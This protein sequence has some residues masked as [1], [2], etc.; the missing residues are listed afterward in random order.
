[1]Y[2]YTSLEKNRESKKW[3][4]CGY[5]KNTHMAY[6]KNA[7]AGVLHILRKPRSPSGGPYKRKVCSLIALYGFFLFEA[8]VGYLGQKILLALFFPAAYPLLHNSFL[9]LPVRAL[10]QGG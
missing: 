6:S 7:K 2:Y 1:M 10:R 4:T 8:H 5:C 3:K 9:F